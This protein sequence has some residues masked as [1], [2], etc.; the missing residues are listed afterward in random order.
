MKKAAVGAK[1]KSV[2]DLLV[3]IVDDDVSVRRALERLLAS[4]G[5][6]SVG[7][8][9]ARDYLESADREGADCL[10]LDLH[11]PGMSGVELLEHLSRVAP[12]L[13]VICMTGRAEPEIE[14]RLAAAGAALNLRK[15]FDEAELFKA[16]SKAM[17]VSVCSEW[18]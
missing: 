7:H 6:R 2:S 17:E 13:P 1:R 14:P 16:L 18:E 8:D 11:L 12:N 3:S 5:L 15:P 4:I 10:L 9:S